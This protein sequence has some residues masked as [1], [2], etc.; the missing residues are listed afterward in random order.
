[1]NIVDHSGDGRFDDFLDHVLKTCH[2]MTRTPLGKT[3][4]LILVDD[5]TMRELNATY[6]GKD[7]TTDVLTFPADRDDDLGDVFISMPQMMRQ[8]T[9]LEHSEKRE[10]AFLTI[11]GFLHALGHTHDDE[12]CRNTMFDLQKKILDDIDMN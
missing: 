4:S 3:V 8:A 7:E 5:T 6:R 1:M 10:L 11:H 9:E 2:R 12:A